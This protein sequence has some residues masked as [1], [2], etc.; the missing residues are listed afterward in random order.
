[1]RRLG[2]VTLVLALSAVAVGG[3][4][5]DG[6]SAA[7]VTAR[8]QAMLTEYW[9]S[10]VASDDDAALEL[11]T[12]PIRAQPAY[13]KVLHTADAGTK[14]P[15]TTG[16]TVRVTGVR[17]ELGDDRYLLDSQVD[18]ELPEL[19]VPITY[20]DFVVQDGDDGMKLVDYADTTGATVAGKCVLGE[21]AALV[22]NGPYT[23]ELVA[24]LWSA[25]TQT[26]VGFAVVIQG[27]GMAVLGQQGEDATFESNGRTI[28][29][30]QPVFGVLSDGSEAYLTVDFP[31]VQFADVAEGGTLTVL[32][33]GTPLEL[34]V[35][36][37]G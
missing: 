4:T 34:E 7:D 5:D 24:G 1:M 17:E 32:I 30:A 25:G 20:Q 35:P 31:D 22:R 8:A 33:A 36:A 9:G 21:G 3:C 23:G 14:L 26:S 29:G 19:A 13:R 28:S 12:G 11:A 16:V 15:P 2:P 10:L 6:P 18:I 27:E 37:F